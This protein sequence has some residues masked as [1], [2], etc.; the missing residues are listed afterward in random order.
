MKTLE[1]KVI[2]AKMDKTITVVVEHLWEHPMYGKRIKRS[3]KYLVHAE[4]K[5]KE[6]QI[7]LIAETKPMSKKKSW[8][9]L[10]ILTK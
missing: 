7:V 4:D 3:K 10:E 6:G 5:V 9:L 8:K 2:S 1:G